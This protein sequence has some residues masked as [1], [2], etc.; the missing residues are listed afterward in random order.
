MSRCDQGWSRYQ[1]E[2][3]PCVEE[4]ISRWLLANF[5]SVKEPTELD[6]GPLTL[7]V[8]QNSA[9]KST[10]IQSILLTCQTLQGITLT[11]PV[12]L[13]GRLVRLGS[14]ADIRANGSNETDI[15]IGFDIVPSS[16]HPGLSDTSQRGYEASRYG[17]SIYFERMS[18]VGGGY[19]FSA[20]ADGESSSHLQLLPRLEGGNL[21]YSSVDGEYD[22]RIEYRRHGRER[23][24]EMRRLGV[25]AV[26]IALPDHSAID[27]AIDVGALSGLSYRGPSDPS[28][29]SCGVVLRHF[30]PIALAQAYD[31]VASETDIILQLLA[32][33]DEVRRSQRLAPRI[34]A[35]ALS[36]TVFRSMAIALYRNATDKLNA[37]AKSRAIDAIEELDQDFT[38][39]N[40]VRVQSALPAPAR[41]AV[42]IQ[43]S[44]RGAELRG[45]LRAGRSARREISSSPIGDALSFAGEYAERFFV[46]Q[47]RYLGPLRDEP[48]SIYPLAGQ[49]DPRDVGLKGEYTAA[50]FENN[51]DALITYVP[52][53]LFPLRKLEDVRFKECTLGE[54]VADWLGYLG[55]AD[56][57][58]TTDRGKLGHEL[59]IAS[60]PNGVHH[61]LTHVGVGV[62][63][64]LPIV[65]SS[66]LAPVGA[67]LIFEQPELHL[68]PRVQTRLADFFTSLVLLGKQCIVET[69]S[70]YLVSRLRLLVTTAEERKL[71]DA[72]RI[73]FV[74][75]Q[76][77]VSV[78]RSLRLSEKGTMNDWPLGFFDESEK[79]AADIL[80]VQVERARKR[81]ASKQTGGSKAS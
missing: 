31:A 56:A 60:G 8:G 59:T 46:E 74:E 79:T 65:V 26:D 28:S 71:A 4:M 43:L 27:Y 51:K 29:K 40:I 13:N 22:A 18:S 63:Q 53:D 69:H 9:G 78:Y 67:S 80:R 10:I 3:A 48:K 37:E 57:V 61:D 24:E 50:V 19:T 54:A 52:S 55:I 44:E 58:G 64:A 73:F 12:L 72:I 21:S 62:S 33:A 32:D 45:L 75:K 81:A 14:F 23:E 35:D 36:S 49:G 39:D 5:K 6:L 66:L 7:F 41:T 17:T 68:N 16:F 77:G 15:S 11:R 47:I 70:E 1:P 76:Q 2:R 25:T 30:V 42:K 34:L 38:L 20:G